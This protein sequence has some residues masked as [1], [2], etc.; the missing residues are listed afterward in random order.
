M[1]ADVLYIDD[2]TYFALPSIDQSQLKQFMR[3]PA[4]WGYAR[5]HPDDH[6]ATDAM[7]FGTAFH[8]FLLG[9]K[10]VVSLPEGEDF[11][12]RK[13]REWRDEQT[14]AG[15]IVVSS[16]DM[17]LLERMRSNIERYPE[18]M[19]QIEE[20][21][22]EVA[23]EWTD[24]KTGL[25]LKAKPDLIPRGTDYL[26]D[27]KTASSAAPEDFARESYKYGYH[28]QAQFYRQAVA[29]CRKQE[30]GR[31][32]RVPDAMQFWVFEKT[33]AC[34]WSPYTLSSDNPMMATAGLAIRQTLQR[35]R[36][37][38]KRGE[39]AGLGEGLEAA[40]LWAVGTDRS[41]NHGYGKTPA[42]IEYSD[43]TLLDAE[44]SITEAA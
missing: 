32:T 14:A 33:G 6:K 20:G 4:E 44:R 24:K 21:T 19:N 16:Q 25:R 30:F 40:A 36:L 22:A 41:G 18:Y 26:V 17:R 8:A 31:G 38:V 12:S 43:W 37:Y 27:L 2:P 34:D 1:S 23:I 11:K 10:P 28:I 7:R 15:N 3:N 9:N 29:A 39:E 35:I 5:L 42:E 13:N